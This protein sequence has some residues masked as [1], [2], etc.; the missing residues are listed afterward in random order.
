[1]EVFSS[2]TEEVIISCSSTSIEFISETDVE[3]RKEME[4]KNEGTPAS[5]VVVDNV[6]AVGSTPVPKDG[7]TFDS[8]QAAK[9]YYNNYAYSVGFGIKLRGTYRR[10]GGEVWKCILTCS[11]EGKTVHRANKKRASGSSTRTDCQAQVIA[12]LEDDGLW[13]LR[14]VILEHNHPVCPNKSRFFRSHRVLNDRAKRKLVLND[15]A[16]ISVSKSVAAMLI[17]T[18]GVGGLGFCEKDARNFI[19]SVRRLRLQAGDAE[20]LRTYL[21]KK[22]VQN[23][24]FFHL[25]DIDDHGRLRNVFWADARARSAYTYFNDVMSFDTTYLTNRYDMPFAPFVGVNHHGQTILLGCGLLSSESIDDY[26][27]LFR[28]WLTCM[29]GKAPSAI[30]T[31]QCAAIQKAVATIFPSSRH[32]L[33]LWHIMRKVPEK[34]GGIHGKESIIT[35]VK[36]VV[37]DSLLPMDFERSWSEM[38]TQSKLENNEWLKSIYEI[39]KK[40]VP[41][42]VKD[43]FWA[44]M[45]TTQRS[46]SINAF[47]DKY[48]NSRTSL[49][50][51]IEQY[52]NALSRMYDAELEADFKSGHAQRDVFSCRPYEAQMRSLYTSAMFT[53]FQDELKKTLNCRTTLVQSGGITYTYDVVEVTVPQGMEGSCMRKYTVTYWADGAHSVSCV[54][55]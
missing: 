3:A 11:K 18:R 54:C 27:W 8:W 52:D 13:H 43:H 30:I 40:W 2:D 26:V 25:M 35:S 22:Q 55:R 51:F 50:V 39:R 53:K 49:Q 32:R 37:Y 44:G 36:R 12:R 38:I 9:E 45:S 46:E 15:E 42:Y 5:K 29:N 47:F 48:V 28:S 10:D 20:A 17:E 21:E 6:D 33:C 4:E 1:M 19:D 31:D 16:G 7:M 41:A 23:S 34:L 24:N 14:N